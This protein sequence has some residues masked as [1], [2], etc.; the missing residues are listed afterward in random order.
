MDPGWEPLT[1]IMNSF[2]L[3]ILVSLNYLQLHSRVFEKLFQLVAENNVGNKASKSRKEN[4]LHGPHVKHKF[5]KSLEKLLFK[6]GN[7]SLFKNREVTK[8]SRR[9]T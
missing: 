9:Q 3:L 6:N 5:K 1:Y 8:Q 7:I 4:K 2:N